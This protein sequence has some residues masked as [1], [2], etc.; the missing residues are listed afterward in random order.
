[1][2]ARVLSEL[3]AFVPAH[4]EAANLTGAVDDLLAALASV[5][6]R[7]EV[8]IVDD[9]S[10]D[11]TGAIAD[12]LAARHRG[13][14]R[15]VRH[16]DHRGYGSALRSGLAAARFEW[17]FFTDADRQF[18]PGEIPSL[19]AAVGDAGAAIGYRARRADRLHRRLYARGWTA[20]VRLTVGVDVRDV[21][22]AFKL[23]RR[24]ALAGAELEATGA[25]VSA[26]ILGTI[27]R[28]GHRLV[29]IPVSHFPRTAG[30]PSG[31]QARVILRAIRELF[32][33]RRKLRGRDAV[34]RAE[35]T[36]TAPIPELR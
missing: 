9:G 3:S 19:V 13:L 31:G 21:N 12:G 30:T 36:S 18:D 27:I 7:Y 34:P 2:V 32:A 29:E 15:V 11:G 16:A 35:R 17:I 4:D 5:A 23:I 26:E 8:V 33:L 1:M 20:L 25:T 28:R 10:R 14:V 22:C 24:A 6:T